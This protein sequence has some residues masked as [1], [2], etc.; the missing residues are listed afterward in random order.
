MA[1]LPKGEPIP[2]GCALNQSLADVTYRRHVLATLGC[3]LQA[4]KVRSQPDVE[5]RLDHDS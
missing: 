3:G 4:S 5:R 2:G 1:G